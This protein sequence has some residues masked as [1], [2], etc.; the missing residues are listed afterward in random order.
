MWIL[1]RTSLSYIILMPY[2]WS[3]LPCGSFDSNWMGGTFNAGCNG[4]ICIK[5]K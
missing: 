4:W 1:A 3:K 5:N 2:G